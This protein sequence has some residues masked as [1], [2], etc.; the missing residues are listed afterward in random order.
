[1]VFEFGDDIVMVVLGGV[2]MAFVAADGVSA[3]VTVHPQQVLGV[4]AAVQIELI[5]VATGA[6]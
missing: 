3:A 5:A 4:A 1:M 6:V 2:G